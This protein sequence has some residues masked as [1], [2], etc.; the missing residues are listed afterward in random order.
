ML[1]AFARGTPSASART[2]TLSRPVSPGWIPGLS[3]SAPRRRLVQ[4]GAWRSPRISI[5]PAVGSTSP[6]SIFMSVDLPAPLRPT[7]P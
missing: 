1:A 3:M 7:K 6:A 5:S 4:P 2:I